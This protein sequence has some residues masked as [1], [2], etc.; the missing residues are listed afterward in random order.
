MLL[1]R[2]ESVGRHGQTPRGEKTKMKKVYH[3]GVIIT[4][5]EDEVEAYKEIIKQIHGR[6]FDM[7]EV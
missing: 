5:I 1:P 7:E 6:I 3:I 4:A 2:F